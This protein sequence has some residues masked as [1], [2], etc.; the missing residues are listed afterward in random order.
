VPRGRD[1]ADSMGWG[2]SKD[3]QWVAKMVQ[4]G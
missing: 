3:S 1:H 2:L 4:I